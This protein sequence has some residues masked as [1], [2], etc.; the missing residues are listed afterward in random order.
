[1]S[2]LRQKQIYPPIGSWLAEQTALVNA[3][4]RLIR[5]RNAGADVFEAA[6]EVRAIEH[7]LEALG[8]TIESHAVA[9]FN[10]L[11]GWLF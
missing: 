10:Q 4:I 3:C 8:I 1:M 9:T 5:A 2:F 6:T 11:S 7:A